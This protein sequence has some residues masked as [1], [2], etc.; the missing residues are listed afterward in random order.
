MI[1][2]KVRIA[3]RDFDL[4]VDFSGGAGVTALFGPS[5]CGKTTIIRLVAGLE[6]PTSGRI[7]LGEHVLVDT[8]RRIA[9]APHRRRVGLVFQDAQLFPHLSVAG[10]LGYGTFFM[11]SR[12]RPVQREAVVEVL[13]IGH[14][15]TRR[16]ATLS[17]GEKQ[18]VAIGRALLSSPDLL[19]M[20]EPLAALDE[21]R[22]QEIL[23]FIERLRDEFRIPI[24]YVSHAVEEVARLAETVVRLERGTVA[25]I[26]RPDE[27]LS[28]TRLAHPTDRFEAVSIL[29]GRVAVVDAGYGV[30]TITHPAGRLVVP[31]TIPTPGREV[32]LSV[33][34]TDVLLAKVRPEGLSARSALTGIV[35][36]V[37]E[38]AG[39]FVRV[40][41][42]LEG[43]DRVAAWVTRQGWEAVGV[44]VGEPVVLLIKSASLDERGM[45][46]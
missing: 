19:L 10:N 24:L 25:A 44:G 33:R 39:A 8:D 38:P 7:V 29:H 37:S 16:P 2:V 17:G 30:T 35:S 18:R 43:G 32:R 1:E 46:A 4:D 23:P 42:S 26:G 21:E 3:R 13:G 14:L 40:E 34:G 9:V 28:P 27:V 15:M 20:D 36:R 6:R 22:K 11:P 31:V 41:A 5:G 12:A 45:T